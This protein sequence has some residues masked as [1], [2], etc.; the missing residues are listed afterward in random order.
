MSAGTHP[1]AAPLLLAEAVVAGYVR[2]LPI[3]HGV[4]LQVSPGEI[5]VVLG[6]NGAGKST[7]VK[8][9]AGVVPKF[10]GRVL[11]GDADITSVPVHKLA[12]AGVGFVPQTANVFTSLTV[13]ENLRIGG[14]LLRSGELAQRLEQAYARFPDLARFRRNAGHAL[15]GGQR[16]ML[17][18]GRALMTA[19]RLLL[20]DEPSAGLS[21][22]MVSEVFKQVRQIADSGIAVLMVEQNVKAGLRIADRG[23]ILV[24]G[25]AAHQGS[26]HALQSDPKVAELYLGRHAHAAAHTATHAAKEQA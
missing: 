21:P 8:S 24:S 18:I 26:A 13:E 19:P 16:Q 2:D 7:L 6:P 12:A 1:R 17:A 4:S 11:L 15:S 14:Y 10:G 20:L 9:L 5:L 23:L 25:H 22:L 3:V